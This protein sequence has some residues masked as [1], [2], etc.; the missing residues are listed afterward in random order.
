[1]IRKVSRVKPNCGFFCLLSDERLDQNKNHSQG[2][3]T[4][5][6]ELREISWLVIKEAWVEHRQIWIK[7]SQSK[8]ASIRPSTS[9]PKAMEEA[10][11]YNNK[12]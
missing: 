5:Q 8:R 11:D 7:A 2:F 3:K 9:P 4:G 6:N 12:H 10:L 1:M